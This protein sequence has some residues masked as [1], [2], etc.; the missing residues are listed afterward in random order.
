M[1]YC[2]ALARLTRSLAAAFC[3]R[4]AYESGST[5]GPRVASLTFWTVAN[6]FQRRG[7]TAMRAILGRWHGRLRSSCFAAIG[8]RL[9]NTLP[10]YWQCTGWPPIYLRGGFYNVLGANFPCYSRPMRRGRFSWPLFVSAHRWCWHCPWSTRRFIRS[11]AVRWFHCVEI[12]VTLT[13]NSNNCF[14]F[15]YNYVQLWYSVRSRHSDFHDARFR[16]SPEG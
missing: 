12:N 11:F 4:C 10:Y 8:C 9:R 14:L 1:R 2:D 3:S 13:I 16:L 5:H 15:C 6:L 7:A